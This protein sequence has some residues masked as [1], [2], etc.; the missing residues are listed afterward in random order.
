[1]QSVYSTAPVDWATFYK[2][3]TDTEKNENELDPWWFPNTKESV[4]PCWMISHNWI[5]KLR[6]PTLSENNF[7]VYVDKFSNC[8]DH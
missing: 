1:M 7:L 8:Q 6:R 2:D 3:G 5:S 4:L